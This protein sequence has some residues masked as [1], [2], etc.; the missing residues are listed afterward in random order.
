MDII[1]ANLRTAQNDTT[2]DH[3]SAAK[4]V[5]LIQSARIENLNAETVTSNPVLP[6]NR[7]WAIRFKADG[8]VVIVLGMRDYGRGWFSPY[9]AGLV[10][11][12]LGVPF[13]RVRIY[14]SA[15][16][17][18][19]LQ[20][21]KPS[22]IVF[23]RSHVGPVAGAVADIIDGLCDQVV[24][25]GRLAFA[26]MAGVDT[27][28]VGFDQLTGRFFILERNRSG[29]MLEIAEIV[30][31]GSLVPSAFA[32]NFQREGITA[33]SADCFRPLTNPC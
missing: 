17:P 3:L 20:T 32:R 7:K 21:P 22:S 33:Q 15:A 6:S 27:V 9:F 12:R 25:K 11:A 23:H 14:Y 8:T 28:D 26:A 18:A 24:E 16:L 4:E 5:C 29:N 30:R 13:R 1:A 31:A 2:C 10:T 19:V